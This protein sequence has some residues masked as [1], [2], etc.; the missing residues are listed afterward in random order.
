M[1]QRSLKKRQTKA[2]RRQISSPV[3][4][5]TVRLRDIPVNAI[6]ISASELETLRQ[7]AGVPVSNLLVP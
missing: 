2:Q 3:T 7:K 1:Q 5:N 6:K 4:Y